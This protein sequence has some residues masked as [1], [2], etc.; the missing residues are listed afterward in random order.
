[1]ILADRCQVAIKQEATAGTPETLAAAD[2]IISTDRPSW[3]PTAELTPRGF[4]SKTFSPRGSVVGARMAKISF[5]QYL[6]GTTGAPLGG[7]PSPFTV[8]FKGCGM[9]VVYS[10]VNPNEI[11]TWAP[12]MSQIVDTTTGAYCTVAIYRDGKQYKIH[13]AV[14]D[15]TLTFD[16]GV[17]TLAEYA[18]QGQYN[19]PTDVGLLTPTYSTVVEPPFL[20]AT[21]SVLGYASA[22]IKGITLKLNNKIAMRPSPAT[23]SGYFSAQ[24]VDRKPTFTID[25]EEEL[26]GTKDW[27]A[28]WVAG[29]TGSI[30]TGIFPSNGSNYNQ[31]SLTIPLA[32][33]TKITWADR[34]GV[35]VAQI[36]GDCRANS[37][38]GDDEFTLVQ[39]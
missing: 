29:T 1:M 38:A 19:T 21:M 22:L 6:A 39:T 16:R 7:N 17:P 27:W 11:A 28:A 24:I 25:P 2:V 3:E 12:S 23:L 35:G 32:Q 14:G 18:F 4:M 33:A 26:A 37:D 30:S 10:G 15:L 13:G 36:E 20:G 34:E 31:F 5:K 8:P 9:D